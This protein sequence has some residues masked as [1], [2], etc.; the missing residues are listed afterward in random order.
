VLD[1]SSNGTTFA[2]GTGSLAIRNNNGVLIQNTAGT[3]PGNLSAGVISG[4]NGSYSGSLAVAGNIS[5]G[6]TVS[7][8]TLSASSLVYSGGNLQA[9]GNILANGNVAANGTVTGNGIISNGNVTANGGNLVT[10]GDYGWLN[11]TYGGGWYMSDSTWIRAVNN[12]GILT[13]GD[14]E[15]GT[16]IADNQLQFTN[17]VTAGTGCSPTGATAMS[18]SGVLLSCVGGTWVSAAGNYANY[19]AVYGATEGSGTASVATCPAGYTLI[20]GGYQT[21]SGSIPGGPTVAQPISNTQYE[22]ITTDTTYGL[23]YRAVAYCGQ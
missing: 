15:G 11:S 10:S 9:A 6:G 22:V 3:A 4:T 13:A 1:S 16:L 14:I 2:T 7:G 20:S 12:K 21:M 23:S 19:T 5:S 18:A 17:A 8:S